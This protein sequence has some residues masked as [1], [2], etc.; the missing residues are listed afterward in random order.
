MDRNPSTTLLGWGAV[1]PALGFSL[2]W[3]CCLPIGAGVL[4]VGAAAV[5]AQLAVLRPYFIAVT[6]LLLGIAFYRAY[7]PQASEPCAT[8]ACDVVPSRARQRLM[9]W[10][11][12]MFA[13]ALLTLPSWSSWVI[14]WSL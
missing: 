6:V 5:A 2:S 13:T 7:A 3:L 11:I 4:G 9:L 8:G 10:I 1:L 14:C 12:A